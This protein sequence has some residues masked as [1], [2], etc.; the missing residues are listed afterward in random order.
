MPAGAL[1]A[2]GE[3][4]VQTS[5]GEW[6]VFLSHASEDKDDFVRPLAE[7]LEQRGLR[8]W[9]DESTLR[10]GDS[11]RRSIDRGLTHSKFGIVVIS[12]HFLN[13][14][15]PQKELDGL[16]SRENDGVKVILPVWHNIDAKAVREASP[17]LADRVA[18][19]SSKGLERVIK[20]LMQEISPAIT[21]SRPAALA[22][23]SPEV[24]QQ[25]A[26]DTDGPSGDP[27]LDE[28]A[29]Q[30]RKDVV[31]MAKPGEKW[32]VSDG[33]RISVTL[34]NPKNPSEGRGHRID[35]SNRHDLNSVMESIRSKWKNIAREQEEY[36]K[37]MLEKYGPEA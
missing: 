23:A 19:S 8:V 18:T 12:K 7:D 34:W 31:S 27:E 26:A 35:T 6:D 3:H 22:G 24:P 17:I 30:I 9:F 33:P 11:L 4:V 20:D 25:P 1:A 14:E 16:A 37:A 29:S 13:K 15:W 2:R 10:V 21:G 28:L 5:N 32:T 36:A